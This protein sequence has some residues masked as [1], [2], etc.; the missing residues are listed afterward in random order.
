MLIL[1]NWKAVVGFITFLA[2]PMILASWG[3]LLST[4]QT[5]AKMPLIEMRVQALEQ[6]MYRMDERYQFIQDA[7][8]EIKAN[9]ERLARK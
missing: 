9:Q 5:N 8:K 3:F 1:K 6:T 4:S 7:L 2:V